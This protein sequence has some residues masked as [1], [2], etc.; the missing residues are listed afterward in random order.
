[1]TTERELREVPD[2][3]RQAWLTE[4]QV[5]QQDSNSTSSTSWTVVGIFFGFTTAVLAFISISPLNG[6]PLVNPIVVTLIGVVAI[7]IV[8]IL[9]KWIKRASTLVNINH[10]RMREIEQKLGMLKN[11]TVHWLDLR[12][13]NK[14]DKQEEPKSQKDRMDK[15]EGEIRIYEK[16][17]RCFML[18]IFKAIILL[19]T[20]FI[21]LAWCLFILQVICGK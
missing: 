16:P 21:I 3:Q 4:Y 12:K 18:N 19:W 8:T 11:L 20:L 15:V 2:W 14:T 17:A 7:I 10:F 9:E 13:N 1:M 5:C 6:N